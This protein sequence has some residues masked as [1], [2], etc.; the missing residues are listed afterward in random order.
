MKPL[1]KVI[2]I[3]GMAL[4]LIGFPFGLESLAEEDGSQDSASLV[5]VIV[6]RACRLSYR[7]RAPLR[8]PLQHFD[9]VVFSP[10]T[11]SYDGYAGTHLILRPHSSSLQSLCLLRC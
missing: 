7:D 6:P 4:V 9:Q 10:S 11:G 3:T 8:D 5:A 1:L 2:L